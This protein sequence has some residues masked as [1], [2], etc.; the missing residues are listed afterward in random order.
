MRDALYKQLGN[1][2]ILRRESAPRTAHRTDRPVM[3]VLRKTPIL[4][5]YME[6]QYSADTVAKVTAS[7]QALMHQNTDSALHTLAYQR[8]T[9][10]HL[11]TSSPQN[12]LLD[13]PGVA[14]V[15]MAPEGAS[16]TPSRLSPRWLRLQSPRVF[17]CEGG[18]RRSLDR[19]LQDSFTVHQLGRGARMRLS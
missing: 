10:K 11:K 16:P 5:S 2:C 13:P 9:K 15:G 14:P 12:R 4:A 1:L 7:E 6:E 19:W 8:D 3:D 18:R 17:S